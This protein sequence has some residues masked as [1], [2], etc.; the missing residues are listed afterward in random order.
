MWSQCVSQGFVYRGKFGTVYRCRELRTGLEL[1]AKRIA[2][3]RDADRQNVEQEVAIMQKM[4]HP[5]IAQIYDAFATKKN[6][7]ILIMEVYDDFLAYLCST[8][9]TGAISA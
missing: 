9:I 7:I 2:I 4:R 1:A 8:T 6:D 5:R 3:K